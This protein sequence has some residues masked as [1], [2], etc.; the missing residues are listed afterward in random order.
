MADAT[1][2]DRAAKEAYLSRCGYHE[3]A[4]VLWGGTTDAVRESWVEFVR[5]ILT[6]ALDVEEMALLVLATKPID[7]D[8]SDARELAEAL[9]AHLLRERP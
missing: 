8:E 4:A 2:L 5:P 7:L 9:R 6:A 1:P 3:G